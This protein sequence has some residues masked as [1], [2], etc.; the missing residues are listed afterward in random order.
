MLFWLFLIIGNRF[1]IKRQSV[2]IMQIYAYSI[3]GRRLLTV[4]TNVDLSMNSRMINGQ[5]N[6]TDK[7]GLVRKSMRRRTEPARWQSKK[8][9]KDVQCQKR[10]FFLRCVPSLQRQ[11][12]KG[13]TGCYWV[14]NKIKQFLIA[15]GYIVIK[16]N[17]SN[18][19]YSM[20][21]WHLDIGKYIEE[22]SWEPLHCLGWPRR[23]SQMRGHDLWPL[24]AP[25]CLSPVDACIAN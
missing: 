17:N 24:P 1:G 10:F 22:K 6:P 14:K 8:V 5:R 19:Q 20:F 25:G 2:V 3:I 13:L 16:N 21:S 18:L 7:S 15:I 4:G 12:I 9:T 23:A 11:K